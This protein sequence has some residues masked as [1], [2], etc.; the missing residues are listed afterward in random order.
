MIGDSEHL[1]GEVR[2]NGHFL[3]QRV[4]YEDTDFSGA[5]YHARYLHFMER[6]RSDYLRL[7][8]LH[9][10]EL[11]AQDEPL[12]FAVSNMEIA[13]KTA[14]RID[15]ILTI[16][17]TVQSVT[18]ARATLIQRVYRGDKTAIEASVTAVL[19]NQAGRPKRFPQNARDILEAQLQT[20]RQT[21]DISHT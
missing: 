8:G 14:C 17:T 1:S 5:V 4:Y 13:F 11:A 6:G 2:P 3:I 9:H 20:S 7:L 12:N 16:H 15:D 19:V 18:G 10:H 21:P